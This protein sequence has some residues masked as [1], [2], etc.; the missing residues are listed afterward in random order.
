MPDAWGFRLLRGIEVDAPWIIAGLLIIL[1]PVVLI[2]LLVLLVRWLQV[3]GESQA[4]TRATRVTP[5]RLRLIESPRI[6]KICK[7]LDHLLQRQ[8]ISGQSYLLLRGVVDDELLARE[9]TPPSREIDAS[10]QRQLENLALRWEHRQRPSAQASRPQTE[11]PVDASQNGVVEAEVVFIDEGESPPKQLTPDKT[12]ADVT[13]PPVQATPTTVVR[14]KQAQTPVRNATTP[15]QPTQQ[16]SRPIQPAASSPARS[17]AGAESGSTVPQP[18]TAPSQASSHAPRRSVYEW[19][20][21]FMEEKNIRWGELISGLLI[22]GS[23]VGLIISLRGT[24]QGIPY[25]SSI[26][27]MAFTAALHGAGLYTMRRWKL[28]TTSRGVLTIGMLLIPLNLLAACVFPE[29]EQ[30]FRAVTDP[31]YISAVVIGVAVFGTLSWA[32]SRQL[33]PTHW[34]LLFVGV[35]GSSMLQL[36]INRLI[37]ENT[38]PFVANASLMLAIGCVAFAGLMSLG[39]GN[40]RRVSESPTS[41]S[42]PSPDDASRQRGTPLS[43]D[44]ILLI[45]GISCFAFAATFALLL[46]RVGATLPTLG[47]LAPS[48][49]ILGAVVTFFGFA[50]DRRGRIGNEIKARIIG[51]SI[52]TFGITICAL[53]VALATQVPG[54]LLVTT[55][56]GF[57]IGLVAYQVSKNAILLPIPFANSTIAAICLAELLRGNL[58]WNSATLNDYILVLQT[59]STALVLSL[60]TV[61]LG[62]GACFLTRGRDQSESTTAPAKTSLGV[63]LFWSSVSYAFFGVISAVHLTVTPASPF[64]DGV[65]TVALVAYAGL[66][67]LLSRSWHERPLTYLASALIFVSSSQVFVGDQTLHALLVPSSWPAL[68]GWLFA[69]EL[70]ATIAAL[71]GV[72]IRMR[73]NKGSQGRSVGESI[74]FETA[75]VSSALSLVLTFVLAPLSLLIHAIV[76]WWTTLLWGVIAIERKS[77]SLF[78]AFQACGSFAVG[79]TTFYV[80]NQAI[81]EFSFWSIAH[82]SLQVAALSGWALGWNLIRRFGTAWLEQRKLALEN[83]PV[84]LTILRVLTVALMLSALLVVVPG[85]SLEWGVGEDIEIAQPSVRLVAVLLAVALLSVGWFVRSLA[86]E[87]Q[88]WLAGWIVLGAVPTIELSG[89]FADTLSVATSLR[90]LFGIYGFLWLAII[91][92]LKPL[93]NRFISTT[94]LPKS[95]IPVRLPTWLACIAGAPVIAITSAA[96]LLVLSGRSFVGPVS[97]SLF[98]VIGQTASYVVPLAMFVALLFTF[99]LVVRREGYAFAGAFVLHYTVILLC[100]LTVVTSG[101]EFDWDW[102]VRLAQWLGFS[103]AIYGIAW[104]AATHY[105][106]AFRSGTNSGLRFLVGVAVV[107]PLVLS[108]ISIASIAATP[109]A[110]HAFLTHVG[111]PLG[112]IA[113]ALVAT[114]AVIHCLDRH[115]DIREVVWSL[116]GITLA[117]LIVTN[118]DL[119]DV[120]RSGWAY[121]TLMFGL[122]GLTAAALWRTRDHETLGSTKPAAVTS[123]GL[124]LGAMVALLAVRLAWFYETQVWWSITAL[125]GMTAVATWKAARDHSRVWIGYSSSAVTLI[126]LLAWKAAVIPGTEGSF[127]ALIHLQI[128]L[129]SVYALVWFGIHM[130]QWQHESWPDE[131][132]KLTYESLVSCIGVSTILV[133]AFAEQLCLIGGADS[134]RLIATPLGLASIGAVGVVVFLGMMRGKSIAGVEMVGWGIAGVMATTMSLITPW[135]SALVANGFGISL[136]SA[137]IGALCFYRHS[138]AKLLNSVFYRK[139]DAEAIDRLF[140]QIAIMIVPLGIFC[141]TIQS[142]EI[143]IIETASLRWLAAF[144]PLGFAVG[145]GLLCDREGK[146]GLRIASL[147]SGSLSIL[148]LV[149]AAQPPVTSATILLHY[150]IWG[151]VVTSTLIVLHGVLL[152]AKLEL[153]RHWLDTCQWHLKGLI[154]ST[155]LFLTTTL[156]LEGVLF[157]PE[158]GAPIGIAGTL[159]V[160]LI[161]VSLLVGLFLCAA[162]PDRF[163]LSI[164]DANR[165]A[166][167]YAG[168]AIGAITVVHVYLCEPRLFTTEWE[169]YWPYVFMAIAFFGVGL[170][171]WL[172]RIGMQTV[173]LP[174]LRSGA[175]LPL[176]PAIGMWII[177][178][179]SSHALIF[180][181]GG[182]LYMLVSLSRGSLVSGL[183]SALFANLALWAFYDQW[184]GLAFVAHPQLWLIPPAISVLIAAQIHRA[185]LAA[186]QLALVRYLCI[187]AIYL[188]ST[189]EIFIHGLGDELWPPM[190]MTLLSVAGVMLGI[191]FQIRAYLYLGSAFLFFSIV[192]MVSH[193]HQSIGHVWPWWAFG[194]G[195][196]VA[197]LVMFGVLEKKRPEMQQWLSEFRQWEV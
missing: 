158:A 13:T 130:M 134:T 137:A 8:R 26:M 105:L 91:L 63:V 14:E 49:T 51:S 84:D 85:M 67:L 68:S 9:L 74:L 19:L 171:H 154:V 168:Q 176:I 177:A 93:R 110:E 180:F 98:D 128:L 4:N 32:S 139:L 39:L 178:N 71:V 35:F 196:G 45:A 109:I 65:A 167:I 187:G 149:V 151:L 73:V 96:A 75:M 117:G 31:F 164:S 132:E 90:W 77:R 33:F 62:L 86:G 80:A 83:V 20:H 122:L 37:D 3:P 15:L 195:L 197:I 103:V 55:A 46:V 188:S 163:G 190:V 50:F 135:N 79:V 124:V 189:A 82:V 170:A 101:A 11:S 140:E 27:A 147:T 76:Y 17:L 5:S 169:G 142:I 183:M 100:V 175:L 191:L 92:S 34:L 111:T 121:R 69:I 193:A 36:P 123:I 24:L 78:L 2:T 162:A 29:G 56:I 127:A 133:L 64:E 81:P 129:H 194:I 54:V 120:A 138:F 113:F 181:L 28:E 114:L 144:T 88:S 152:H 186:N 6:V 148:L 172:D 126:G 58:D 44:G 41:A 42:E 48:F 185:K 89:F 108:V 47:Y 61:A 159:Y 161:L 72:V 99:R 116:L 131:A 112:Y 155:S 53:S 43:N 12:S 95:A 66:M 174:F 156:V 57:V 153:T 141:M 143:L 18:A 1:F 106:P 165:H 59:A 21:S 40:A 146:L 30:G 94:P 22:V 119:W 7:E 118:I 107:Y 52:V 173:S 25:F 184:E 97:G 102:T 125:S 136:Y 16:P 182:L 87:T 157:S 70:H 60:T 145:L 38:G 10:K 23:A 192:A 150:T 166:M 104:Q 115:Q 160:A 179:E